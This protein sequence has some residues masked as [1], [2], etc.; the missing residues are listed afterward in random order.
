MT[1]PLPKRYG[2]KLP[3]EALGGVCVKVS[4]EFPDKL[5]YRAAFN[6]AINMLGKWFQ[7][8]HTQAD[9]DDIP[10]LNQDVAQVWSMVLSEAEWEQCM[11]VCEQLIAC[12]TTDADTQEALAGQILTNDLI[13]NAVNQVANK[14]ATMLPGELTLPIAQGCDLDTL[15]AQVTGI[16]DTMNTNNVDFLEIL[17]ASTAPARKLAAAIA[18]IP[19]LETLPIDDAIDWVAK[20]QAE[21]V[22]NYEAQYTTAV[23]DTYRCDLFCIAQ[24]NEDCQLTYGDIKTYFNNRLGAALD[25][26][27]LLLAIV[28]YTILGTWAGTT[29]VDIMMLNQISI[30][31]VAG[32]WLGI[33]LRT[34]QAI[35]KISS[36]EPDPDWSTLCDE[37]VTPTDCYEFMIDDQGWI[38]QGNAVY[39]DSSGWTAVTSGQ[40]FIQNGDHIKECNTVKITFNNNWFDGSNDFHK[41]FVVLSDYG[42]SNSQGFG[43]GAGP[44]LQGETITL[45]STG[46][47][48]I[49]LNIQIAAGGYTW[50]SGVYIKEI[51][52]TIEEG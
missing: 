6:G 17:A 23:R 49:G 4:I 33:N 19:V 3:L 32:D 13:R 25:P 41:F 37:C 46:A 27:H 8:D 21:I 31:E 45:T 36:N 10:Q 5:E 1:A 48:W 14:G 38:D 47:N 15:F 7:W 43:T 42:G 24:N 39:V 35:T 11:E 2:Y 20:M 52:C 28:Q 12:L 16:I 44:L 51:C 9:Y 50:P 29:V 22:T 40:W 26:A 34:L 18:A 30:W